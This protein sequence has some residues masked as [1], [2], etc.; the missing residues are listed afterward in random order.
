MPTFITKVNNHT[1]EKYVQS[2]IDRWTFENFQPIESLT[3][4]Q[5]EGIGDSLETFLQ[6]EIG[7]PNGYTITVKLINV[8]AG[9]EVDDLEVVSRTVS[10]IGLEIIVTVT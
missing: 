8:Q 1:P 9:S 4:V 5:I 3:D 7:T 10:D 2:Y 6:T